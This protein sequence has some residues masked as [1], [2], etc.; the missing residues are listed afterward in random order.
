MPKN[1]CYIFNFVRCNVPNTCIGNAAYAH[2]VFG[3]I[4]CTSDMFLIQLL[5]VYLKKK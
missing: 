5:H 2:T 4:T 1:V 3:I